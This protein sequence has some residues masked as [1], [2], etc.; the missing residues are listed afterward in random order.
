MDEKKLDALVGMA[1]GLRSDAEA[2][3]RRMD[4]VEERRTDAEIKGKEAARIHA[5]LKGWRG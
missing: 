2:V 1:A 3:G 4:G 5:L